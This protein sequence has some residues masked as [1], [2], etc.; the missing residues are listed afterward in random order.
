MNFELDQ[1]QAV[2]RF[3][4]NG[5]DQGVAFRVAKSELA[6]RALF[7]HVLTKNQVINC[8]FCWSDCPI[9]R[10]FTDMLIKYWVGGCRENQ[11]YWS[12]KISISQSPQDFTVNFG[13]MP[14]P[15]CPLEQGYTP[16]GQLDFADGIVRLNVWNCK[17]YITIQYIS[18]TSNS[19]TT[20]IIKCHKQG[21]GATFLQSWL[22]SH[23]DD[24]FVKEEYDND[25]LMITLSKNIPFNDC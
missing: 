3:S 8:P 12:I 4:V 14:G 11:Q 24:R 15:L 23:H 1:H 25:F 5:S 17:L 2:M 7:P 9:P 16:I 22:W 10:I 19:A 21:S 20:Q 13:Q 6:G 18:P